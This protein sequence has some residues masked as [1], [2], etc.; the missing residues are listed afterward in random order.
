MPSAVRPTATPKPATAA[1]PSAPA[2]DLPSI[3]GISI[4]RAS[5][6]V[7]AAAPAQ[8]EAPVPAQPLT[9]ELITRLWKA[10]GES[11]R[12]ADPKTADLITTRELR[13][14]DPE[15][16]T[17]TIVVR[18]SYVESELRQKLVP[19]LTRLRRQ[20][21]HPSLNATFLI[22]HED[23]ETIIYTPT[24]KFNAM[25]ESNPVIRKLQILLP[26]IDF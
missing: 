17:F 22:V 24:D 13:F 4:R 26:E 1:A 5:A 7:R 8:T 14:E 23:A 19:I 11:L 21:G 18:N 6:A 2:G 20:T 15:N 12:E 16:E 25:A 3:G 10:Y 9:L